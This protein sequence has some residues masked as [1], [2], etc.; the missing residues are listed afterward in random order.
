M[1][2]KFCFMGVP[3][4]VYSFVPIVNLI[5]RNLDNTLAPSQKVTDV[6]L[7]WQISTA[8]TVLIITFPDSAAEL[9][10]LRG[11]NNI[12]GCAD[13]AIAVA[14]DDVAGWLLV[15]TPAAAAAFLLEHWNSY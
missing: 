9:C 6:W 10:L 3:V 14:E 4:Q 15:G 12:S 2:L 8:A 7:E 5:L 11:N 1:Y 13:L